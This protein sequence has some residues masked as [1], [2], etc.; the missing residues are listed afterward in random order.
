M[1]VDC[2]ANKFEAADDTLESAKQI[3]CC[4][5][6]QW[7]SSLTYIIISLPIKN[8]IGNKNKNVYFLF[9]HFYTKYNIYYVIKSIIFL[10]F[11][12]YVMLVISY[13]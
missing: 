1:G 7:V 9:M 5:P 12:I 8:K 4:E 6:I 11:V 10:F 2:G 13:L 3:V